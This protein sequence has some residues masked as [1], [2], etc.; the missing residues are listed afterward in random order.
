[1]KNRK[2]KPVG[3]KSTVTAFL[4]LP[5]ML[6]IKREEEEVDEDNQEEK[7]LRRTRRW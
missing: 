1:V 4:F 7:V 5:L 3:T 2:K 6:I